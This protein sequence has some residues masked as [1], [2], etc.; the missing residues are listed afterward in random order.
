MTF[1]DAFL[2]STGSWWGWEAACRG[3]LC[4]GQGVGFL[5]EL[6]DNKGV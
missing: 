3:A 4:I 6:V 1:R 2:I 5:G